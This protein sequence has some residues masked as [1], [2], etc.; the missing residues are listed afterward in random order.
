MRL[1]FSDR[2]IGRSRKLGTLESCLQ[3]VWF[4]GSPELQS[5]VFLQENHSW[6]SRK[7]EKVRFELKNDTVSFRLN[8]NFLPLRFSDMGGSTNSLV[9]GSVKGY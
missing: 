7:F 6:Q 3:R 5:A 4:E 2:I 1:N 9:V 8:L